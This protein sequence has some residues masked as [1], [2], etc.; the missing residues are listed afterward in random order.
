[1]CEGLTALAYF[2]AGGRGPGAKEHRQPAEATRPAGSPRKNT[3]LNL[4]HF[5]QG[6]PLP[7]EGEEAE[8]DGTHLGQF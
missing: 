2:E 4:L 1:M 8:G 7:S 6:D 5:A 3:A